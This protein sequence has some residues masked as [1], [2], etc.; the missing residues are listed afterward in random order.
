MVCAVFSPS[1]FEHFL[2]SKKTS[3]KLGTTF[4]TFG[5]CVGKLF[6]CRRPHGSYKIEGEATIQSCG[7]NQS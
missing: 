6:A 2:K 1:G 7:G 5:V 3:R 4:C